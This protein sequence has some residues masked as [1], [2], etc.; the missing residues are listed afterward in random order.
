MNF[1][2]SNEG[3]SSNM[4]PSA[5]VLLDAT[6][7]FLHAAWFGYLARTVLTFMFWSSALA[8][9]GDAE[10]GI[11]EMQHFSLEPAIGFYF[12]T[13]AA[14]LIGSLLVICD[15]WVWLGAGTLA[16]FTVLTIPIAHDFWAMEEPRR[17]VEF[18]VAMEHI[19]VTGGLLVAIYASA[20]RR[21]KAQASTPRM[22]DVAL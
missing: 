17:T 8:K 13:V 20:I 22:F 9:L 6:P 11:A 18:H 19:T 16:I 15:R 7:S 1:D 12:L 14:L 5:P 4:P 3:T 2:V 21:K 10:A